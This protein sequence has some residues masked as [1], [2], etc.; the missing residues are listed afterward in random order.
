MSFV[1]VAPFF[2][3]KDQHID[4]RTDKFI[5]KAL[6][7][8]ADVEVRAKDL[9]VYLNHK[10]TAWYQR[11]PPLHSPDCIDDTKKARDA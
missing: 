5:A 10:A 2:R 7:T 3:T 6:H 11:F 1:A 9:T 4:S 8:L